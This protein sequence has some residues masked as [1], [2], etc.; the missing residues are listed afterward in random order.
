MKDTYSKY[1]LSDDA[2]SSSKSGGL[3]TG[4]SRIR[5]PLDIQM[6]LVLYYRSRKGYIDHE[7][8]A[9]PCWNS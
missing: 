7:K 4:L 5:A 3:I 9:S 8:E 2:I 1:Y 6:C